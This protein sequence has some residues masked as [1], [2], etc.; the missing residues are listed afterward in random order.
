MLLS[1][2]NL[3]LRAE[4]KSR[5]LLPRWIGP[6]E[7]TRQAGTVSFELALTSPY[8]RLHPVF[9][10]SLLRPYVPSDAAQF[11]ERSAAPRPPPA[12][13]VGGDEHTFVAAEIRGMRVRRAR[14]GRRVTEYLVH[15]VSYDDPADDTWGPARHL[16][17]PLAE[18][19]TWGLVEAYEA[20]H[21]GQCA[22]LRGR[23][24]RVCMLLH[25]AASLLSL[26]LFAFPSLASPHTYHTFSSTASVFPI[27]L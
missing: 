9:H 8:T 20:A 3:H 1:T 4:G 7:I 2:A 5:K 26:L 15:W 16:K 6:F 10:A 21:L 11:P 22:L 14:N 12:D 19:S 25:A 18:A 27:V 13:M 24:V 17:P 23:H